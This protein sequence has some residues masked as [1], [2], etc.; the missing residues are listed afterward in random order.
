MSGAT[1]AWVWP[2]ARQ[3]R[4]PAVEEQPLGG[5]ADPPAPVTLADGRAAAAPYEPMRMRRAVVQFAVASLAA[6]AVA[7]L[8]T[9][10]ASRAAAE[11]EAIAEAQA[12]TDLLATSVVQPALRD[13]LLLGD[14]AALAHLDDVVRRRVLGDDLVRVKVWSSDG[15]I[16]YSDEPRLIG[17]RYPLDEDKEQILLRAQGGAQISDMTASEND[18]ERSHGRLLEVYRP[19]RTPAGQVLLFETY[20]PFS[21]LR[22]KELWQT[23]GLIAL[24]SVLLLQ[25]LQLPLVWSLVRR[26]AAARRDRERLLER[27]VAASDDERRRIAADVHD[28]V[29]QDLAAASYAVAGAATR[30]TPD[31]RAGPALSEA[32]AGIRH[33]V[34]GLRTM[35]VEIYPQH[36]RSAGLAAALND[37][38]SAARARG[39]PVELDV[40]GRLEI[41]QSAEAIV[42][43]ATQE[44]LRNAA[45]HAAASGAVVRL[46]AGTDRVVLVV[47]DDGVGFDPAVLELRRA[48]GHIGLAALA[49]L[50]RDAGGRLQVSSAPGSGTVVRLEVPTR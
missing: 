29:L 32:E 27:A 37:L 16:V 11:R 30:S 41:S 23:F 6:L 28:G 5:P 10:L 38:A 1:R 44:A 9:A 7:L 18:Y 4:P 24:G 15:R 25:V 49:D 26:L 12:R 46:R 8:V 3:R 48:E 35:L 17:Q 40:A 19:V 42:F 50:V 21:N 47:R 34:S 45:R 13:E 39:M 33:A 36:L 22:Q 31:G 43:R 14:A 20:A 2:V